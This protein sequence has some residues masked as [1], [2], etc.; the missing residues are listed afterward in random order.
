MII[1]ALNSGCSFCRREKGE[2][3]LQAELHS[4]TRSSREVL[5]TI[6]LAHLEMCRRGDAQ[7]V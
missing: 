5:L 4:S 3:G 6:S 1:I 7:P 2:T